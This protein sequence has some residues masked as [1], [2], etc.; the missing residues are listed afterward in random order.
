M[1]NSD[2]MT[3]GDTHPTLLEPHTFLDYFLIKLE[4]LN[5]VGPTLSVSSN[6]N[7]AA[8]LIFRSYSFVQ[9]DRLSLIMIQS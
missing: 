6:I 2:E 9:T 8:E 7:S 4:N 3:I 5:S 1:W